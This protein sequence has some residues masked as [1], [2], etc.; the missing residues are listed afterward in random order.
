MRH[1]DTTLKAA[2]AIVA[3]VLIAGSVIGL[4][5]A[6]PCPK[7][8]TPTFWEPSGSARSC[9]VC[10]LRTPRMATQQDIEN[11]KTRQHQKWWQFMR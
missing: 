5:S 10:G 3:A 7:C 4:T 8:G 1:F 6:G 11:D 2:I 9:F